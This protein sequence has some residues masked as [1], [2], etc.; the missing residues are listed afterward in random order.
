[1]SDYLTPSELDAWA[2]AIDDQN[3]APCGYSATLRELAA[4]AEAV[5]G[6]GR[7]PAARG[8]NTSAGIEYEVLHVP[9]GTASIARKVMGYE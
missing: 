5:A 1:M 2:D 7:N 9:P 4:I 3:T 6:K 8:V